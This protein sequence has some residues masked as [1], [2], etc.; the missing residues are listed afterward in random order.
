[1]TSSQQADTSTF[2]DVNNNKERTC[3][4]LD[5][6]NT[7]AQNN[8]RNKNCPVS[9]V[10]EACPR[11][12]KGFQGLL[13]TKDIGLGELEDKVDE[14]LI[15]SVDEEAEVEQVVVLEV[16]EDTEIVPLTIK[17][18]ENQVQI[19]MEESQEH[20]DVKSS[21]ILPQ[22]TVYTMPQDTYFESCSDIQGYFLNR[23]G[24]MRQCSWLIYKDDP[25][26]DSRRQ[27]NCGGVVRFRDPSD[28]GR[29][30][31]KTCG[32]NDYHYDGR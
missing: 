4:W 26:D 5:I 7:N 14:E 18:E 3:A 24:V 22:D 20:K 17:T 21:P 10:K 28:L 8:R 6:R 27:V 30:C 31:R 16:P 12:C 13:T 11:S 29:M 1:M 25:D 32:C 19:D 2:I 15:A 23:N 9:A